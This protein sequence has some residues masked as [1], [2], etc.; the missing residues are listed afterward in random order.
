M[1]LT[2][3]IKLT[4]GSIF[5]HRMRSFLTALGISIGIAAVVLLTSIGEGLHKYVMDE[6]SQF[7]TNIISIQP[8]TTTTHG[9]NIAALS[10]VRPLSLDDA[11]ALEKI[12][13]L[14]AVCPA[15]QGNAEVETHQRQRR[16]TVYGVGPKFH[17]VY[18]I[19]P[20]GGTFLPEDDQVSPRAYVV[21]GSKVR[22]E[23][24]GDQ[25]PLGQRVRVGGQR[26]RVIG[27]ME[28]KGQIL[29]IDLDDAVYI[30]TSRA[31]DL[32]NREGL[33][34]INVKYRESV[35]TDEVLASIKR[36]LIARHGSEDF[37]LITQEQMLEVLS[38]VLNVLTFAV[39]ALGGISLFVG[40]IG[41]FTIMT[42]AVNERVSEIG[43]LRALG[44]KKSQVLFIF[45]GEAMVL[46]SIG[47]FAGLVIGA[48]G[49]HLLGMMFSALPVHTPWTFVFI[50]EG[51][52]IFIGLLAGV[53]PA[54][55]ASNLDPVD[56]LRTE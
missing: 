24:Y 55:R 43:L 48:G 27:V 45:L 22:D 41:V 1:I 13:E 47:G 32:F 42:I 37:T 4:T 10:T 20:S 49:A 14:V 25:N 15:I 46:A 7:G 38:S 19:K 40:A 16:T 33:M 26:Y 21:L 3:F 52:A 39:G 8:G 30:P 17:I 54:R 29:G 31:M 35:S 9:A 6:F 56:A 5:A 50:A 23:L 18:G 11:T 53:L 44:A 34:E 36:T 51:I 2:D 12:P 28:S